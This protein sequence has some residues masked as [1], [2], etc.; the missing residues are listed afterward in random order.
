CTIRTFALVGT[1]GRK[2][3]PGI[4]AFMCAVIVGTLRLPLRIFPPGST[5][6][7]VI[8]A[9]FGSLSVSPVLAIVVVPRTF[10]LILIFDAEAGPPAPTPAKTRAD[11]A[12]TA[13]AR[14]RTDIEHSLVRLAYAP[15]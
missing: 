4:L 8:M 13:A 5:R 12:A 6:L 11:A 15:R 3:R 9:P 1:A 14:L 10:A 7:D 2:S